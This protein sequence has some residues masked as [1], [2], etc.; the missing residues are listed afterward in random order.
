M[1]PRHNNTEILK[2][3]QYQMSEDTLED[4]RIEGIMPSQPTVASPAQDVLLEACGLSEDDLLRED[5]PEYH[6]IMEA[7]P[8]LCLEVPWNEV[9]VLPSERVTQALLLYLW[10]CRRSCAA[11]ALPS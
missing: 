4:S 10:L 1:N 7:Y 3:D 6:N 11:P 8:I 5:N 9:T 2:R